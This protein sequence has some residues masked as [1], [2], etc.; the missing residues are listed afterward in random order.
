MNSLDP[1][2]S[3]SSVLLM[4]MIKLRYSWYVKVSSPHRNGLG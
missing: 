4:Q 3:V 1:D 2:S